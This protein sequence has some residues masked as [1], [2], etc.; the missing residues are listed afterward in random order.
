MA[1][2]T[3]AMSITP[4]SVPSYSSASSSRRIALTTQAVGI[5]PYSV[6]SYSIGG[7]EVDFDPTGT[8]GR[9]SDFDLNQYA[10]RASV[11]APD[12]NPLGEEEE[13]GFNLNSFMN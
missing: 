8:R 3:Q 5:T 6:P 7:G 13:F 2:T 12:P 10:R 9:S 1:L 4:A 11:P